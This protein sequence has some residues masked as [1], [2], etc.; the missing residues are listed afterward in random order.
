MDIRFLLATDSSNPVERRSRDRGERLR[1]TS[2]ESSNTNATL[3]VSAPSASCLPL[4]RDAVRVLQ[5]TFDASRPSSRSASPSIPGAPAKQQPVHIPIDE[6]FASLLQPSSFGT[7]EEMSK[8]QRNSC[9]PSRTP[10]PSA[11]P[12]VS[13]A[14][15]PNDV[16][17]PEDDTISTSPSSFAYRPLSPRARAQVELEFEA[18]RQGAVDNGD[19]E[20]ALD[21]LGTGTPILTPRLLA[22]IL[23][24]R[25]EGR[26]LLVGDPSKM[27]RKEKKEKRAQKKEN[28]E[29]RREKEGGRKRSAGKA[30]SKR[31]VSSLA[32]SEQKAGR[33]ANGSNAGNKRKRETEEDTISNSHLKAGP[34][35]DAS[36]TPTMTDL[37]PPKKRPKG[38]KGYALVE[39]STDEEDED[40]KVAEGDQTGKQKPTANGERNSDNSSSDDDEDEII[41]MAH[42]PGWKGWAISTAPPDRSKLILLD[43]APMVTTTRSTRSGRTF[44]E[45]NFDPSMIGAI[46]PSRSLNA[47]RGRR[48][49]S[50]FSARS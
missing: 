47:S 7:R 1:S 40:G 36:S 28:R 32:A 25:A 26:S 24:A 38:W 34:S 3:I 14:T 9:K 22:K 37:H 27:M 17:I 21:Y 6:Q 13:N 11:Q 31:S 39:V 41:E 46:A 35:S 4:R 19:A 50:G 8:R 5:G 23:Q 49:T 42:Q 29:K 12:G 15:G 45:K 43:D 10:T 18:A 16:V 44:G 2:E 48:S 33:N 20:P 30:G